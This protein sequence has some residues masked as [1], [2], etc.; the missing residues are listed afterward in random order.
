MTLGEELPSANLPSVPEYGG[1]QPAA[2]GTEAAI[3]PAST[4]VATS[5]PVVAGGTSAGDLPALRASLGQ[6]AS[7]QPALCPAGGEP[8]ITDPWTGCDGPM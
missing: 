1:G 6:L 8:R 7:G 3:A 5:Q 4:L 2:A